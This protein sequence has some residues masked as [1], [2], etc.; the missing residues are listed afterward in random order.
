MSGIFGK[1]PA[2]DQFL[3]ENALSFMYTVYLV[4]NNLLLYLLTKTNI[5]RR[6]KRLD[7]LEAIRSDK[8]NAQ[9]KGKTYMG[10][11]QPTAADATLN[12]LIVQ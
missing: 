8:D 6:S 11:L 3:Q 1:C 9:M 10:H 7:W 5:G 12:E 4:Y 2:Q